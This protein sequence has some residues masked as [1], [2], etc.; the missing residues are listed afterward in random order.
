MSY[1]FF[2]LILYNAI[3]VKNVIHPSLIQNT[4]FFFTFFHI[5]SHFFVVVFN[6]EGINFKF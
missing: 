2:P 5:L 1:E 3:L 4:K 6:V